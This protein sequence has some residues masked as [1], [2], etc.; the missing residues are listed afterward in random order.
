MLPARGIIPGNS[1]WLVTPIFRGSPPL[2]FRTLTMPSVAQISYFKA[3]EDYKSGSASLD[4]PLAQ[5]SKA[6]GLKK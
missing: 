5:L 1:R 4:G 6:P 3:S 2:S